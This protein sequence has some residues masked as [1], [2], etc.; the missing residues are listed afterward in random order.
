MVTW[1]GDIFY[2]DRING[3]EELLVYYLL[4]S[5]TQFLSLPVHELVL[6]QV[7]SNVPFLTNYTFST[8]KEKKKSINAV[9]LIMPRLLGPCLYRNNIEF[10][11]SEVS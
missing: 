9:I 5:Q 10:L 7:P 4:C 3:R 8:T 11:A 2:K 1:H 6:L